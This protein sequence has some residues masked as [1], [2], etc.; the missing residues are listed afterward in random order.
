[1][2]RR[3]RIFVPGYPL[4]VVQRG[5]D[6]CA[7]FLNDSDRIRYLD[8]LVDAAG[9]HECAVHCYVL[10]G[11]HVHLLMT[12]GT[13]ESLAA[14][15]QSVGIRYVRYFNTTY[16]R[17]GGLWEGRYRASLVNT[18]RYL[19]ACYRYIELNPVRANLVA[20][21]ADWPWSSHRLHAFGEP[22]RV[23]SV[24]DNYADLGPT[25]QHRRSRYRRWFRDSPTEDELKNIRETIRQE[26]V[27]GDDAFK[28]QLESRQLHPVRLARKGR[29]KIGV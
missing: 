22:D 15:M 10:M 9:R 8:F 17:T 4:H 21:P 11:N 7:I 25:A 24:H 26:L 3:R 2:T 23:V 12:P 13:K 1:M 6:R 28:Q 16:E 27:L 29:E 19:A 20:N 5:N 18:D 14:T